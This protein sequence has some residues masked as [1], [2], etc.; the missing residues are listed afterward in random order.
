MDLKKRPIGKSSDLPKES[1]YSNFLAEG[2]M[3]LKG[4]SYFKAFLKALKYVTLGPRNNVL[5]IQQTKTENLTTKIH[6]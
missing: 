4:E 1:V 6:K 3:I 2:I 5:A